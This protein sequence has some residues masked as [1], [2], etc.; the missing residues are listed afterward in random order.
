M[1]HWT[2]ERNF[3]ETC[4]WRAGDVESFC[5][6]HVAYVERKAGWAR[7][8]GP[9]IACDG[10]EHRAGTSPQAFGL[11]FCRT[12][13]RWFDASREKC[14]GEWPAGVPENLLRLIEPWRFR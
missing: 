6:T 13:V 4:S 10:H 3:D 11:T 2:A 7:C 5:S 9:F 8:P 12:F 14:P 1:P